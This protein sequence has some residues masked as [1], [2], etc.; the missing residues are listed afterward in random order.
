MSCLIADSLT[1]P[2]HLAGRSP[3]SAVSGPRCSSP[4]PHGPAAANPSD[5]PSCATSGLM[6]K[7]QARPRPTPKPEPAPHRNEPVQIIWTSSGFSRREPRP[8]VMQYAGVSWSLNHLSISP[9]GI[10][11]MPPSSIRVRRDVDRRP[12][13]RP[14]ARVRNLDGWARLWTDLLSVDPAK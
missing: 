9:G 7:R 8:R 5:L 6:C 12:D 1:T 3:V 13:R 2:E 10:K 11:R 4:A 14:W